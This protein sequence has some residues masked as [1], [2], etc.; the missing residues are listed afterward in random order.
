MAREW[1][2]SA[3]MS[4]KRSRVCLDFFVQTYGDV[5]HSPPLTHTH[6]SL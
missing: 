3:A 6:T 5:V 4:W 2:V 1:A